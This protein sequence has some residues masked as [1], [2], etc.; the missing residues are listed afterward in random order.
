MRYSEGHKASTRSGIVQTASR[1]FRRKGASA[2]SVADIMKAEGLTHGGFY[3]HFKDKD[4][5]LIESVE[6]ALREVSDQLCE[7]TA[8]SVG[9]EALKHL[10]TFYLSEAHLEHPERGCAFAA[11]G[12]ELARYPKRCR[13]PIARALDQYR[14]RL[15]S[16]LPGRTDDER[17]ACFDVLF[18][19]MAGCL[20]A[21]RAQVDAERR[22]Q[23]LERARDFFINTFCTRHF[24]SEEKLS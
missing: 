10:I 6:T 9:S 8:N 22:G 17:K 5:L 11:L 24:S 1:E 19:S 23:I 16:L 13:A 7:M 20:I 14:S 3:R 12:A 15:Q 4:A 21:A 18:P 2:V